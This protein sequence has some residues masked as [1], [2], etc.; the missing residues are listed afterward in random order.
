MLSSFQG[1]KAAML[2]GCLASSKVCMNGLLLRELT[3]KKKNRPVN[4]VFSL[5]FC[6]QCR[7]AADCAGF[8]FADSFLSQSLF[9]INHL[10]ERDVRPLLPE[11]AHKG[12]RKS[13]TTSA[14]VH[15][16]VMSEL[17]KH[18][19]KRDRSLLAR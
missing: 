6:V 8:L 11:E 13:P 18:V 14:V 9:E 4:V 15:N 3:A 17:H 2:M 12:L 19:A 10:T 16:K 1:A 5:I 7:E